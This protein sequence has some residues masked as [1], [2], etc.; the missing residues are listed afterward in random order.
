MRSKA[1]IRG[2]A[3]ADNLNQVRKA[4]FDPSQKTKENQ[5]INIEILH[6]LDQAYVRL[7][8]LSGNCKALQ[9]WCPL[10]REIN[11]AVCS[12]TLVFPA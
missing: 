6:D 5:I 3:V 12:D 11:I 7:T 4:C 1:L 10:G 9:I 8:I 2:E